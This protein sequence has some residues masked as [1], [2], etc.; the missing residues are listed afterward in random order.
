MLP[1]FAWVVFLKDKPDAKIL[2]A[3]TGILRSSQKKP[4]S[5]LA[6][7]EKEFCMNQF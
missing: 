6:D 4:E 5:T 7:K 2:G 3:F 1:N